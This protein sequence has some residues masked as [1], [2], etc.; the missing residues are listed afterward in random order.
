MDLINELKQNPILFM[1]HH[2]DALL[3]GGLLA[4]LKTVWELTGK[5]QTN[6]SNILS[7]NH[8]IDASYFIY[9][10]FHIIE[11]AL[12]GAVGAFFGV[13]AKHYGTKFIKWL[14]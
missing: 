5:L 2:L 4:A 12:Y 11:V 10:G 6:V 1:K 13:V 7:I 9:V 14:K 8:T 3:G